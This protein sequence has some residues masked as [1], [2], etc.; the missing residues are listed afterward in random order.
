MLGSYIQRPG[1]DHYLARD[2][3]RS[4]P[5]I[6]MSP[7]HQTISTTS[8]ANLPWLSLLTLRR[9]CSKSVTLH[10]SISLHQRQGSR[11][12]VLRS[13]FT[14]L[15][16]YIGLH[17]FLFPFL[18]SIHRSPCMIQSRVS[19]VYDTI[20]RLSCVRYNLASLLCTISI[21]EPP[22]LRYVVLGEYR[23]LST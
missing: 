5:L 19:L 7:P 16:R 14:Y 20:S 18:T 22:L 13:D 1:T 8:E 12:F 11:S 6:L 23:S 2:C 4:P 9:R 17:R 15:R 3:T 21:S 10:S